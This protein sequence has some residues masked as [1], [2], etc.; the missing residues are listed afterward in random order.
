MSGYGANGSWGWQEY[1]LRSVDAA[2]GST[3][4]EMLPLDTGTAVKSA[5]FGY[6]WG[7]AKN[8]LGLAGTGEGFLVAAFTNKHGFGS[9]GSG[10]RVV[11]LLDAGGK[12][13]T[14]AVASGDGKEGKEARKGKRGKRGKK[15]ATP[16]VRL[17]VEETVQRGEGYRTGGVRS[18]T[19]A[20]AW[21][22]VRALHVSDRYIQTKTGKPPRHKGDIDVVGIFL[23]ADGQRLSDVAACASVPPDKRKYTRKGKKMDKDD[24]AI[25]PFLVAAGEAVQGAPAVAAGDEGSFLVVWQ[26]QPTKGPSRITARLVRA[27]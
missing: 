15:A 20:L 8:R 12:P 26:E 17:M 21:D 23:D 10:I 14:E 6:A 16:K 1:R 11:F 22:G 27:K 18:N 4:G 19:L 9:D 13:I 3:S 5:Q 2:S 24:P 25:T 7:N